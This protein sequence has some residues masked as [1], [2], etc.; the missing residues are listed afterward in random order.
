ML[1][2]RPQTCR[3]W[4]SP[5]AKTRT[6]KA[7]GRPSTAEDIV[8]LI[9]QMATGNLS[10]GY[11]RIFGELKKLGISVGLTTIRDILKRSDCP[12]PRR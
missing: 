4:L 3:R 8:A 5:K 9:L 6:P 2:V 12:P 10:W 7:A 1:V 11:K